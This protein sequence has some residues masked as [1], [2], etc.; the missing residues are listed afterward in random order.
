MMKN[1]DGYFNCQIIEISSLYKN[2]ILYPKKIPFVQCS[3]PYEA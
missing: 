2:F 1:D 3:D